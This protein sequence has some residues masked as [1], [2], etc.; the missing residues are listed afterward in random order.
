MTIAPVADGSGGRASGLSR[1]LRDLRTSSPGNSHVP[2]PANS[3]SGMSGDLTAAAIAAG[4]TARAVGTALF[5]AREALT[6]AVSVFICSARGI[7]LCLGPWKSAT[8]Q[9]DANRQQ[10][11]R[12]L[13][14]DT[15]APVR[16]GSS[17]LL[18]QARPGHSAPFLREVAHGTDV[19]LARHA[20]W[21]LEELKFSDPVAE[22]R[23]FIRSLNYELETGSLLLARTV[24]PK[25]DI[26]RCCTSARPHIAARCRELIAEPSSR[27]EECRVLNRRPVS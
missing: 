15:S 5:G 23:G 10:A 13:L 1:H 8:E 20:T 12:D 2:L 26:V 11:L 6:L 22:F 27:R 18:Q 9:P 21:F 16:Q 17:G 25:L 3:R 14:D 7:A 24:S 19:A 4:S